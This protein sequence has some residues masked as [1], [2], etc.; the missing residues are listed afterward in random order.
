MVSKHSPGRRIS[1]FAKSAWAGVGGAAFL[2]SSL[3]LPACGNKNGAEAGQTANVG[4]G[5]ST[6][7][8]STGNKSTG[9]GGKANFVPGASGG[10][11]TGGTTQQASTQPVVCGD[12]VLASV[13]ACD[14]GNTNSGDG[15]S[16]DCSVELNYVCSRPPGQPCILNVVCGDKKISG[17]ENCDD[18]NTTAGDGCS[19]Q[20]LLED[21]WACPIV[22]ARCVAAKCGDGLVRGTETCDDGNDVSGDGCNSTCTI[23]NPAPTERDAWMCPTPGQ[24]CVRTTCGNSVVEGTEQCDD[25]N[26]DTGD[27]CSPACRKEPRCPPAGGACTSVCGDGLILASDTDQECDDGNSA[28]GDGCSADCKVEHG[29]TCPA[30]P[31]VPSG[32][33]VLPVVYRDF[34][35]VASPTS[36]DIANG[37]HPD[38]EHTHPNASYY[39]TGIVVPNLGLDGKPVHSAQDMVTTT[40]LD[41]ATTPDWFSL[42]YRDAVQDLPTAGSP[43]Y[44]YT[45][46]DTLSLTETAAGSGMFRYSST[47]FFPLDGRGWGTTTGQQHNFHFTS[48]VRYWF[49]Y[50]G[51]EQLA[52]SGDDDVFVFVNKLLAVDL[53]GIHSSLDGSVTLDASNGTGAICENAAVGCTNGRNV[54]FGLVPGSVYEMVVFQAE[55]HTTQSNYTLTVSSFKA[56]RSTCHSVCGDGFVTPDEACDL[57]TAGNTGAYGTCNHDCT[58]PPSCGDQLTQSPPEQCDDGVNLA[59]YGYNGASVCGPNCQWAPRCGDNNIDS[60]FGEQCDDGNRIAKDGC[61]PNCMLGDSCGNGKLDPGE[62]CDDHN[63]VSGDGC[64]EFC[65]REVNIQ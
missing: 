24:P 41:T 21:G 33:L 17:A 45:F 19:D 40:N 63:I 2:T 27:G 9:T 59:T 55:R 3:G 32:T 42:W 14:D 4:G 15:C 28:N 20:C 31:V 64:S 58:L 65:K 61:E 25:G 5:S 57:G 1:R 13:E 12:G 10:Q 18:G 60:L 8:A 7:G 16:A 23:E 22:A 47:S 39:E 34:K 26:N 51:G 53:G 6:G 50:S 43:R 48:E 38:F 36:A 30:A 37:N 54:D 52:F 56:N 46:V 35:G 62:E 11:G 49:Q 44:N 29:Y